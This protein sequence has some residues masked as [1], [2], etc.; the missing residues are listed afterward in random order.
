VA[1]LADAGRFCSAGAVGAESTGRVAVF[2]FR[3]SVSPDGLLHGFSGR[4]PVLAQHLAVILI[5]LLGGKIVV[6]VAGGAGGL[7]PFAGII[8]VAAVKLN[9]V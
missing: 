4:L 6:D 9:G 7:H 5:I 2:N 8:D 1:A 3:P